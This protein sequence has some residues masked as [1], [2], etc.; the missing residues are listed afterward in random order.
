MVGKTT[1]ISRDL[2]I[3][4]G[5]TIADILTARNISQVE[6]AAQTGMTPAYI[7]NV[8]SGKKGISP[9]FAMAL[10][11]ALDV[12]KSFWLNL[13]ANYES[14]LLEL[15]EA[16]TITDE[17][18]SAFH[19]LKEISRYLKVNTRQS[20][21]QGI[22]A[23]RK[24]LQ[25]SNLSNLQ[26]VLP[27]G[28]FRAST[29]VAVNSTVMGAWLRICQLEGEKHNVF[30]KFDV[31]D[32]GLL[33][34]ELKGIMQKPTTEYQDCLSKVFAAHGIAFSIVPNFRGAPVQGYIAKDSNG[35]YQ[36][37]LTT[38]GA[39]ADIFWFT[40]F[41]EVGHI[42][43]G[44][45]T[46]TSKYI[47]ASNSE[48]I[49]RE[50]NADAF[51]RDALLNPDAYSAFV[52]NSDFSIMNIIRFAKEQDVIPCIVIGRLQKE[53]CIPYNYF[54]AYKTYYKLNS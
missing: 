20:I 26:K 41:H 12:P 27:S 24:A 29:K 11:Y 46:R 22:L 13:Q 3:H 31:R 14:E 9:N 17:E 51:A 15:N 33:I 23:L 40:L 39:A 19:E 53:K 54:S 52:K 47:D 4:P 37:S 50:R 45:L 16:S 32:T 38:R 49:A 18:R 21:E 44:D 35:T 8:I 28:A 30:Q 36:M 7:S 5:E 2:I 1:G 48:N 34:D 6:L 42:V 10:E 25:I 43:N